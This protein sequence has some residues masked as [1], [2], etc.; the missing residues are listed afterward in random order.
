MSVATLSQDG[1]L[2]VTPWKLRVQHS[3]RKSVQAMP[4]AVFVHIPLDQH[5]DDADAKSSS[6]Q[7][8][9]HVCVCCNQHD[10]DEDDKHH[11]LDAEALYGEDHNWVDAVIVR[12]SYLK[13]AKITFFE[14]SVHFVG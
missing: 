7:D 12:T 4:V 13:I 9:E 5:D 8:H 10:N 3:E 6:K 14:A 1:Q 11:A 2:D